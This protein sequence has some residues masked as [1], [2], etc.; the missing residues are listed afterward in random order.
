[1]SFVLNIFAKADLQHFAQECGIRCPWIEL[2]GTVVYNL[3]SKGPI[4]LNWNMIG[5]P[6]VEIKTME[7][8]LDYTKVME[9]FQVTYVNTR[10]LNEEDARKVSQRV[11]NQWAEV[12]SSTKKAQM[13]VED[14]LA[15][16]PT[17]HMPW[18][19]QNLL[20]MPVVVWLRRQW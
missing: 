11:L 7:F 8:A 13:H 1:M 6:W 16:P 18:T 9:C 20:E 2:D 4:P 19:P 12:L 14:A 3:R 5:G 10:G 17:S 15:W